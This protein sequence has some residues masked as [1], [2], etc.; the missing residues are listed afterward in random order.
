MGTELFLK[1][2]GVAAESHGVPWLA[3]GLSLLP[4]VTAHA[5]CSPV[6]MHVMQ[7][8]QPNTVFSPT[9]AAWSWDG[10][11]VSELITALSSQPKEREELW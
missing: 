5:A 10:R 2:F 6:D 8:E 3:G 4:P 9:A 7:R 1:A 11:T